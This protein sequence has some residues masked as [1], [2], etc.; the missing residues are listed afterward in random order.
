MNSEASQRIEVGLLSRVSEGSMEAFRELYDLTHKRIYFYL[1]RLLR[2][3]AL[4]EDILV[5][6]YTEV[7]RGAGRYRGKSKVVTWMIGISRNLAMNELKKV[8]CHED[9]DNFPNLTDGSTA[10]PDGFDRQRC[11]KDAI[12]KLSPKHQ[13]IL[14]LVFFHEMT[15]PEV[16]EILDI[17]V[18]TVKTRIFYAK[19]ALRETLEKMGVAKNDL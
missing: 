5:E 19:E 2:D 7:W 8:K 1:Y 16:S 11:L 17:P 9:I 4:V 6:T 10:D 3:K 13:E 12:L 14:D 15:Y 18:N